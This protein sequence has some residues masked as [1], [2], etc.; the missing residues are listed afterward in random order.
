MM[1]YKLLKND[2]GVEFAVLK[3]GKDSIPFDPSNTDYQAFLKYQ[4]EGGVVLPADD[5]EQ[6][7]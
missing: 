6:T 5:N 4:A 7:A 2:R 3:D 1:T